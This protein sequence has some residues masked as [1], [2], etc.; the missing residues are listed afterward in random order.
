M[1]WLQIAKKLNESIEQT[2]HDIFTMYDQDE[3]VIAQAPTN[4]LNYSVCDLL[5]DEAITEIH[6][7]LK[8]RM[9]N[10][11][12]NFEKLVSFINLRLDPIEIIS[13]HLGI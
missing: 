11:L 2:N 9:E 12:A 7:T 8:V 6:E 13:K 5:S 3:I 4:V 1:A 10:R